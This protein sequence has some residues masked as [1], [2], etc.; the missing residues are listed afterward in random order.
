[1]SEASE[2]FYSSIKKK[3]FETTKMKGRHLKFEKDES[4]A[5][6]KLEQTAEE[7]LSR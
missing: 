5:L 6:R 4:S 1:M 2:R 3:N 7:L